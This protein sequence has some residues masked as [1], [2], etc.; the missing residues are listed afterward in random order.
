MTDNLK[1]EIVKK[2]GNKI[3]VRICGCLI[4]EDKL[5]ML[6]HEGIG[7]KGYY[8]NVPGGNP[9]KGE[10]LLDALKREFEEETFLKVI[11]GEFLCLR[12]FIA[13]PLHAIE[14]YFKV[15]FVSGAA[16]LGSDPENVEILSELKW[17]SA[18]E[19][20]NLDPQCRPDF[21]KPYVY[22]DN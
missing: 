19:F 11:P 20:E 4:K 14:M 16:S 2:Y 10:T 21:L 9:E 3:R 7:Q 22:L 1:E 17:F 12:E 18:Q 15:N 13:P 5:L 6:R 8:W